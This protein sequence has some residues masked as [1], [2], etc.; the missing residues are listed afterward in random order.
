[1]ILPPISLFLSYELDNLNNV[2]IFGFCLKLRNFVCIIQ[3]LYIL[4]LYVNVLYWL[5]SLLNTAELCHVRL[6][7]MSGWFLCHWLIIAGRVTQW[8]NAGLWR[9]FRVLHL[10]SSWTCDHVVRK[11]SAVGQ[12]TRTT[13]PF[14]VDKWAVPCQSFTW[15]PWRMKGLVGWPIVDSKVGY[16]GERH[17]TIWNWMWLV[18][19]SSV[20]IL[21]IYCVFSFFYCFCL[22]LLW[23]YCY[24][25]KIDIRRCERCDLPPT[26]LSAPSC[27]CM[28]A[29]DLR[30]WEWR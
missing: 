5:P 23:L 30:P 21:C 22:S 3:Y 9:T 24:E 10:T 4:L 20:G 15:I 16:G 25:I 29:A 27:K 7:W 8:Y 11:L 18:T 14:R 1:M 17:K 13:Q 2:W 19:F 12:P 6:S 26:S 28:L